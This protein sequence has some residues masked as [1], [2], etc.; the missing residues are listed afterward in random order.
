MNDDIVALA[1]ASDNSSPSRPWLV[2]GERAVPLASAAGRDEWAAA[3]SIDDLLEDWHTVAPELRRLM[4]SAST[5]ATVRATGSDLSTLTVHPPVRPRHIFCTIA[6]YQRQVVEA[7]V[8]SDDGAGGPGASARRETTLAA[9]AA[10][11][12]DGQPYVAL[13]PS[14]R[15]GSAYGDVAIPTAVS[16][17]D[18]EVELAAIIGRGDVGSTTGA[19][20]AGY[21]VANDLTI[22]ERVMR[23]D[24]P[25]LGSDWLQSKGMPGSLPLGPFFVPA[26]LVADVGALRL[27]LFLNDEAM[28]DDTADDMIFGIDEQVA[29]IARHT[30]VQPGDVICTGSPAGF[31]THHRRLLRAGDVLRAR[32]TNLGEQRVRCVDEE[33]EFQS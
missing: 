6:N 33:M 28:Q 7:A 15:I 25:A 4:S 3:R 1:Q 10:R 12:R 32:V 20:V 11:R 8:D 23:T 19:V 5:M 13:T 2:S 29:Y 17:L 14:H 26:W 18:W 9:V 31:G 24:L 30:P 27:E 16:T 21:A 22:R